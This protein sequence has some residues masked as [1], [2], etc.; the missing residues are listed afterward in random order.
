MADYLQFSLRRAHVLKVTR[1]SNHLGSQLYLHLY[2]KY[3]V[4]V[5]IEHI[6]FDILGCFRFQYWLT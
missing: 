3:I 2:F 6:F 1:E 4:T 5:T